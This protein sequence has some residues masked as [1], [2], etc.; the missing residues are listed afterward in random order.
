MS[1]ALLT[2]NLKFILQ[3]RREFF[4]SKIAP[5][6]FPKAE[7]ITTTKYTLCILGLKE[8]V[9]NA[10][11]E[12]EESSMNETEILEALAVLKSVGLPFFWWGS[13]L[14]KMNQKNFTACL[15]LRSH[16]LVFKGFLRGIST[17]SAFDIHVSIPKGIWIKKVESDEELKAFFLVF[18]AAFNIPSDAAEEMHQ[19]SIGPTFR[20]EE[21]QFLAYSD[22]FP[23]GCLS[24]KIGNQT[25]GIW[26]FGVLEEFRKKGIGTALI[27]S[28]LEE[29]KKLGYDNVMAILMPGET[30][31]WFHL[32]FQE[33]CLFPLYIKNG[34]NETKN[35]TYVNYPL[36]M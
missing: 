15:I 5:K 26:N 7:I 28:A 18:S 6:I 24:L 32:D 4:C 19:I 20:G 9:G 29:G 34:V 21:I 11:W 17:H 1:K 30:N 25:A 12:H 31:L 2:H 10:L 16:G 36:H 33:V 8:P 3:G 35:K 22:T 23:V 13:S 14:S 27:Q